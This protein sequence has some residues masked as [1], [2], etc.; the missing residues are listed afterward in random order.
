[1]A[2]IILDKKTDWLVWLI[3]FFLLLSHAVR[4]CA[5]EAPD[6]YGLCVVSG[7]NDYQ[8]FQRDEDDQAN[9]EIQGLAFPFENV[10]LEFR[11]LRRVQVLRG[12]DW[13]Q[14][15]LD[16]QG[17]WKINLPALPVGGPYRIEFRL[18]N[19]DKVVISQAVVHDILVGDLWFLGGQSNMAGSG[20]M[21]NL[22]PPSEMVHVY[23]LADQWQVAQ[24]PLH[25]CAEGQYAIYRTSY[26][27]PTAR[28]PVPHKTRSELPDPAFGSGLGIT[29]ARILYERTNVPIGLIAGALGGSTM[30]QW[31]PKLKS[32]GENSLYWA[33]AKRIS[34]LGG[35]I[36]GILWWQGESDTYN[37]QIVNEYERKLVELINTTRKDLKAP[38]LP[39]YAVQLSTYGNGGSNDGALRWNQVQDIQRTV[40]E[41]T[42]N[43]NL[44]ASLDMP[45]IDA[46]LTTL[47]YKAV[48]H[49]LAK[50]VA[51]E[52]YGDE[53]L[54]VGPRLSGI[55][56]FK[57]LH[58]DGLKLHFEGVNASLMAKPRVSGFSL[59]RKGNDKEL[60]VCN[61]EIDVDSPTDILIHTSVKFSDYPEGVE[62]W[63]GRGAA[64][65]CNVTDGEDM[66]LVM[67]GPIMI[68]FKP[69]SPYEVLQKK[70]W[71]SS[72]L[73]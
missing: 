64:P 59:Q 42:K 17:R 18:L 34:D 72:F 6:I 52:V 22:E 63:Y 10:Q 1:M 2:H 15:L 46:H 25:V 30:S 67:F 61:M 35:N 55:T 23:S 36:K 65:F 57:S 29:F 56:R 58:G 14:I 32:E 44:V 28:R 33:M 62:L 3:S 69:D 40:F 38:N 68:S 20:P 53:Q 26:V 13:K 47:G 60:P 9:I 43:S 73:E 7:A 41:R 8:V 50:V 19:F 21:K 71:I 70:S 12:F 27:S 11:A 54:L 48:G 16:S 51:I 4:V 49:R 45:K 66:A 5:K 37:T 39:F 31:S 24:D